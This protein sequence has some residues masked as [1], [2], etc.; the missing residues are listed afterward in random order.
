[1]SVAAQTKAPKSANSDGDGQA[2]G[3]V[4]RQHAEQQ[5]K[6]ELDALALR[7]PPHTYDAFANRW[8]GEQWQANRKALDKFLSILSLRRDIQREVSQ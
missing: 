3:S 4:L 8:Q 1:M 5:F 2:A 7:V 6:S